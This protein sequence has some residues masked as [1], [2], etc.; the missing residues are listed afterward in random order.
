MSLDA[1]K[2]HAL[3]SKKFDQL[4]SDYQDLWR[5]LAGSVTAHV[6]TVLKRNGEIVRAGDVSA[7]LQLAVKVDPVFE[8]HLADKRLTQKYWAVYFS[9]YIIEKIYGG[10]DLKEP[11]IG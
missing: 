6:Q 10:P 8:K 1:E 4:F 11:D 5:D 2:V 9:D 3:V 7:V